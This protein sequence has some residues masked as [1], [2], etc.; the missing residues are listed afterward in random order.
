MKILQYTEAQAHTFDNEVASKVTGRVLIGKDD[1]AHNF[2]MRSFTLAPG[3]FSPRHSHPWEHEIFVHAG[4]G[5]VYKEGEWQTVTSGTAIF[6]PGGE[7]HQFMNGGAEDFTFI[8]LIPSGV[9]EL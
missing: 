7:E 4:T 2:C 8:C 5:K 3:G 9:D 1:K 6:I